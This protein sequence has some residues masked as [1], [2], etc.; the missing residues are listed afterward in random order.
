MN[1][2]FKKILISA[3]KLCVL[4]VLIGA[5]GGLLGGVFSW[6]LHFV[7]NTRESAKWLVLLLPLGGVLSV[8]LYRV[9]NMSDFPLNHF[10]EVEGGILEEKCA[11]LL[12]DFFKE[13]RQKKKEEKSKKEN[14]S[15]Q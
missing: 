4:G 11:S 7:T 5:V 10:P 6:L 1:D 3:L 9:F 12:S 14:E 8:W 13:L 15:P 2:N